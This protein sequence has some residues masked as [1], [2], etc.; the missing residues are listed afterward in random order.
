MGGLFHV[1]QRRDNNLQE[2]DHHP[3]FGL[4]TV[5]MPVGMSFSSTV[6]Q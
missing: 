4:R 6:L 1:F 5:M 2:L 3:L